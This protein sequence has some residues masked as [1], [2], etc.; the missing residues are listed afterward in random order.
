[1]IGYLNLK[2]CVRLVGSIVVFLVLVACQYSLADGREQPITVRNISHPTA[3]P[4]LCLLKD[5]ECR[6]DT[7]IHDVFGAGLLFFGLTKKSQGIVDLLIFDRTGHIYLDSLGCSDVSIEPSTTEENKTDDFIEIIRVSNLF[8]GDKRLQFT[9][10][11]R[12]FLGGEHGHYDF[13]NLKLDEPSISHRVALT[14]IYF[15]F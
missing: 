7:V 11:D 4:E 10:V 9:R 8:C 12:M 14:N 1:M 15:D 6:S 2:S 5:I 3:T 13:E